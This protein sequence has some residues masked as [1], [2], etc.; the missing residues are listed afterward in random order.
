MDLN[1]FNIVTLG[2]SVNS[3]EYRER[4]NFMQLY[5]LVD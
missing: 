1:I 3:R 2:E 5:K 4:D